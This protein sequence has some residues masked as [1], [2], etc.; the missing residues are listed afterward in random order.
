MKRIFLGLLICCFSFYTFAKD[1]GVLGKTY[2]IKE[3]NLVEL[4]QEKIRQK[5]EN[6]ELDNLNNEIKQRYLNYIERPKGIS[7][8]RAT[9]YR[10]RSFDVTYTLPGDIFDADGKLLFPAGTQVNPLKIKPMKKI[11]CFLDSDDQQQVEWGQHYCSSTETKFILVS[12]AW[13]SLAEGSTFKVYFD[14]GSRL[15]KKFGIEALPTIVRGNENVL[16]VEE[17]P[18]INK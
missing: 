10:A 17:I 7:L 12:G 9:S 6:G 1:Y 11:L 15:V 2:K 13:R 5:T 4:I 16:F 18:L 8:P 3:K 14:Q